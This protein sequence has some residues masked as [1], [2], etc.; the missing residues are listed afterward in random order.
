MEVSSKYQ[1][2]AVTTGKRKVKAVVTQL[3]STIKKTKPQ[4][5]RATWPA[6]SPKMLCTFSRI[7]KTSGESM[8]ELCDEDDS[9]FKTQVKTYS[10]SPKIN[11]MSTEKFL[12]ISGLCSGDVDFESCTQ[13]SS[14]S[15]GQSEEEN[16]PRS[17]TFTV[18]SSLNS[19]V[20]L[21]KLPLKSCLKTHATRG[22]PKTVR[23][24]LQNST[25]V[26]CTYDKEETGYDSDDSLAFYAI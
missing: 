3:L 23:F 25:G 26:L 22:S 1:K 24:Q 11:K 19:T 5:N 18:N 17:P 2:N 16:S 9:D 20:C 15:R 4:P 6:A 14:L 7:R 12:N 8:D 13:A 21:P 10:F